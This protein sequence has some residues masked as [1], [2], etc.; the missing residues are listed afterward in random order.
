MDSR[1]IAGGANPVARLFEYVLHEHLQALV[2]AP[3]RVL[4]V[5]SDSREGA[6]SA[7]F[8]PWDAAARL[9]PAEVGRRLAESLPAGA[10]VL[11]AFPGA[12]PLPA[13]LEH[14]LRGAEEDADAQPRF[15]ARDF[16]RAVGPGLAWRG[17][18]A[19]GVLVPGRR[20]WAWALAH[21]QAFGVLAALERLVRGWPG[22][23]CL[24]DITVLE[25][26]RR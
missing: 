15:G 25:G 3:A 22:L 12:H 4:D 7:G 6:W 10:P 18:F 23:R 19:L 2:P 11:V 20:R 16:R 21:P 13:G 26:V 17:A 9:G 24:G 1:P 14:V 8:V 5:G